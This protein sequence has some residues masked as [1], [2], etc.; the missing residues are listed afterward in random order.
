MSLC[1]VDA[2]VSAVLELGFLA[3]R[4]S[5]CRNCAS[6]GHGPT[7]AYYHGPK[8]E[9]Y[10]RYI[11]DCIGATSSTRE[12]LTQFIT[13]VNSFHLAIKYIRGI[14][15]TSLAFLDIKI[16]ISIQTVYTSVF[17]AKLQ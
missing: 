7:T 8:P 15:D 12:E 2:A 9:L 17:T 14:S 4:E 5:V 6:H 3:T 1:A 13:A 11:N 10:V 16:S